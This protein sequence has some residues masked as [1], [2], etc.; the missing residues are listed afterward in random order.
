MGWLGWATLALLLAMCIGS[1][2]H[3][4]L[5]EASLGRLSDRFQQR[6]QAEL[7]ERF[8]ERRAD[9]EL[10][11]ASLRTASVFGLAL[12]IVRLA[13]RGSA[14]P[15]GAAT[16]SAAFAIALLLVVIF[17]VAVPH[18]WAKYAGEGLL[19][20]ILPVL[21]VVRNVLY[22]FLLIAH[23]ADGLVRRLSGAPPPDAQSQAHELEQEILDAVSEGELHGA[24]DEEA[25]EMIE[26]VIEMRDAQVSEIMTPRTDI[27][28]VEKSATLAD[29]KKL[30]KDEGPS[31]IPVYDG[32]IDTILG[33]LYV[34]DLLLLEEGSSFDC[35]K[36]MRPALFIPETKGV[37]DLLREFRAQKVHIAI[38]L[39]EYGGTAGLVTIEDIIEELVGEIAD[40]HETEEPP[41]IR[42]IDKDTLEVDARVRVDELNEELGIALPEGEDYETIGG[43]VYS[44]LGKIPSVGEK[45]DHDNVEI[46]VIAAEPRRIHRLR[47]H[48]R[49]ESEAPATK[50]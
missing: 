18:A 39:D 41:P 35:T 10:V 34:K 36:I 44:R 13:E 1:A 6:G 47:L 43:F 15:P 49:R 3:L 19:T 33:V 22:P 9:L 46:S 16:Y 24:V 25:K 20:A 17:G 48:I 5:R 50:E 4:A 32:T 37:R 8:L 26:S 27:V 11:M 7:F 38:V 2:A 14:Q 30:I 21:L 31:R 12:V 42:R 28:A 29:I 45:C 23:A 40:E